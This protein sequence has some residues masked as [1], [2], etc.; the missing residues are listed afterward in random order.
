MCGDRNGV[1]SR[2]AAGLVAISMLGALAA[3]A[4]AWRQDDPLV[5]ALALTLA[6]AAVAAAIRLHRGVGR[7]SGVRRLQDTFEAMP[8]G[9]ALFDRSHRLVMHNRLYQDLWRYPAGLLAD[10]PHLS[11]LMRFCAERGDYAGR[12]V[13]ADIAQVVADIDRGLPVDRELM[14]AHGPVLSI[15]GNALPDGGYVYTYADVTDRH[16]AEAAAEDARDRLNLAV[17]ATRAAVWDEHF[18]ENRAWWSPEYRRMLGY[19]DDE[20]RPEVG[21]WRDLVHPDDLPHVSAQADRYLAGQAPHYEAT[22]RMR[23]RDGHWIW[24]EDFGRVQRDA[25]GTPVRFVGIMLDVTARKEGEE[26]LRRAKD[27]A[28]AA[29]RAKA[30]FLATMSHELRTPMNGVLGLLDVLERTDLD[31]DQ[32]G[33]LQVM[34]ESSSTLLALLDDILDYARI[35]A[36]G[37]PA[38]T[39]PFDLGDLVEDV[40]ELLATEARRKAV[41]VV[42]WLD[43]AVPARCLGDPGRLRKVLVHL[44]GNAVKFTESGSVAITVAAGTAPGTAAFTVADTGIGMDAAQQAALFQPFTMA[45]PS[46]TRRHGGS[47]LGLA[48]VGRL[49]AA[50]GGTITVDSRP[51]GGSTF[52]FEIPLT[53][54]AGAA[55]QMPDLA[56]LRVLVLD[57]STAVRAAFA[58]TLA[59]AGATVDTAG[60]AAAGFDSLRTA[61]RSGT[62]YDVAVVDH[63]PG[64]IDGLGLAAA[65]AR[66]PGLRDTRVIVATACAGAAPAG[67][68]G[69]PGVTALLY[70]PVRAGTLACAVAR[71]AGRP[72]PPGL[73]SGIP[74]DT[75]LDPPPVEDAR[76]AGALILVAEDN[77]TNRVVIARHL[78][79]LGFAAD[80]VNDGQEAVRALERGGYGLLITDCFMPVMDGYDLTRRIRAAEADAGG[81]RRLPVVALSASALVGD[82]QRCFDAG[83]DD[84]LAKPVEMAALNRAV[85]RWL[86]AALPLRR[87]AAESPPLPAPNVPR[88]AP[89][90]TESAAINPDRPGHP[91]DAVIDRDHVVATFG[92]LDAAR[93]L[94][95]YFLETTEPLIEQTAERLAEGDGEEVRR[96]AHAAAGAARTAGATELARVCSRIEVAA[97]HG[98]LDAARA[99]GAALRDAFGRVRDTIR[100]GL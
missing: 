6:A 38:A 10:N 43:P 71:A 100:A 77:P 50:M 1:A 45:D 95:D 34:R 65:L 49:V 96:T 76:A 26:R 79:A 2:L 81:A 59:V 16:R 30:T 84:F 86:P 4:G 42:T 60:D 18:V 39:M 75:A 29:A 54:V 41:D 91:S 47:G 22:Y 8:I 7:P 87:A 24:V 17:T 58:G 57:D 67:S 51:G 80:V 55:D 61:F 94:L 85:A 90:M 36:D 13:E 99:D 28:E 40:A 70:K 53:P 88:N 93:D 56:G 11:A 5:V 32:R 74:A 97:A 27:E 83:M 82:A 14:L 21:L 9:V 52:R 37:G 35:E 46:T 68:S 48:I 72:L 19:G 20:I 63:A 31:A 89:A 73:D 64:A 23:R 44:V 69:V 3:G 62:S 15:R 33:T 66:M 25:R 92:S 78:R 12:D 98:D